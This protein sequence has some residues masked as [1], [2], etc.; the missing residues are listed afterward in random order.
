MTHGSHNR[1]GTRLFQ[2]LR[3]C[4]CTGVL[5]TPQMAFGVD[6]LNEV[7]NSLVEIVEIKY[8]R[9]LNESSI[10]PVAVGVVSWSVSTDWPQSEVLTTAAAVGEGD[11]AFIRWQG[12]T[13]RAEVGTDPLG[14]WHHLVG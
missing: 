6:L 5:L 10:K 9:E 2:F 8:D 13:F 1:E 7:R 4:I 3:V 11:I 12:K 14:P